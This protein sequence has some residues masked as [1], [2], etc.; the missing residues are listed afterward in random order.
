M[1]GSRLRAVSS[2]TQSLAQTGKSWRLAAC[3]SWSSPGGEILRTF[4]IITV[5]A[6][7]DVAELHDRMPLIIEEQDWPAGLGRSRRTQRLC[8]IPP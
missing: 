4:T 3:G 2:L 8:S 5:P 1:N 7:A 6:N